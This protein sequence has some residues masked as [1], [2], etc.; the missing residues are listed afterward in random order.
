M[1]L[2]NILSSGKVNIGESFCT[3]LFDV[4]YEIRQYVIYNL[5][6]NVSIKL[7]NMF[8]FYVC[9]IMPFSLK[10]QIIL[11]CKLLENIT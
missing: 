3:L 7:R 10:I 4:T 8:I 6:F 5:N 11:E 9:H 1:S 2:Q